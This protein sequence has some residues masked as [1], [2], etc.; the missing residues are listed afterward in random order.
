M[1]PF[2]PLRTDGPPLQAALLVANNVVPRAGFYGPLRALAPISAPLPGYCRGAFSTRSGQVATFAGTDERLYLLRGADW[3]EAGGPYPVAPEA[4]WSF[5]LFG[6][7]VVACNGVAPPQKWQIGLSTSFEPLGGAPPVARHVAVVRDFVVLGA[8]TGAPATIRWSGIDDAESW[9]PS[10]ESQAD[11]QPLPDGG[12]VR[13]IV[14]G[15]YGVILQA[16]AIRRMS[17][18][19]TPYVFQLDKVEDNRGVLASGSIASFGPS[20]VFYLSNEGFYV[21]DGNGP[22]RPIGS[23]RIDK[24]FFAELDQVNLHRISASVDAINKLYML[25]YPSKASPEGEPD[26]LVIHNFETGEWTFADLGCRQLL[27][28]MS[29]DATLEQLESLGQSDL[30]SMPVS[31][32]ARVWQGGA[33]S[34]AAFDAGNRL[35]VPTGPTLAAELV[36]ADLSFLGP[37]RAD[38]LGVRV[39]GRG[40]APL[41]SASGR[42]RLQDEA[43]FGQERRPN[44]A[45]LAPLRSG[46]RFHRLRVRMPAGEDWQALQAWEP[47]YAPAGSQ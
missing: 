47:A 7:L 27:R 18:V 24:A 6:N 37:E 21:T 20:L 2:G 42:E 8:L 38:L 1:I 25:A 40:G 15:E 29:E 30:D 45:G 43:S 35:A 41:V 46:G 14:G 26:R 32:D 10:L 31:L 9:A 3:Q 34:L 5:A 12:D 22:S 16:N 23:Q 44:R 33:V 19:G 11:G 13:G 28:V 39:L 36:S 17:Y 4:R